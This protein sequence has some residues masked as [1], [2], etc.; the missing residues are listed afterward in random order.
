M[1]RAKI[2]LVYRQEISAK[3]ESQFEKAVFRASYQEFLFKSQAYNPDGRFK[4]FSQM[5]ENDGRANSL[6]YKLGF[7]VLHFISPL[8]NKM[9]V[10]TDNAG[11][12]ISFEAPR[13][14]LI[15][16]NIDDIAQH[17]IAIFYKTAELLL[18]DFLGEYLLLS[19]A[20]NAENETAGTFV[21]QL[22]PNLSIVTYQGIANPQMA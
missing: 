9:P 20:H 8:G 15:E 21:L 1:F 18:V 5:R 16:S 12:K 13:F 4:S 17:Q 10:I 3:S 14:E 22:Q 19:Q 2:K 11:D 7:S 6:H